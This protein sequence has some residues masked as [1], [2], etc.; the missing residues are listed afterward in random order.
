MAAPQ[1]CPIHHSSRGR[2]LSARLHRKHALLSVVASP[3]DGMPQLNSEDVRGF[4]KKTRNK[5]E[6]KNSPR[7]DVLKIKRGVTFRKQGPRAFRS[8]CELDMRH[9]ADSAAS[10]RN[11]QGHGDSSA[12]CLP[13]WLEEHRPRVECHLR[14]H[15][16]SAAFFFPPA[17]TCVA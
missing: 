5:L 7:D 11:R 4:E 2:T 10:I 3:E 15:S 17:G 13:A 16:S 1:K 14:I 6:K 9:H 12:G 8:L